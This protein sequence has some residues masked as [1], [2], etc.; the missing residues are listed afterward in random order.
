V[1]DP[2]EKRRGGGFRVVFALFPDS[3]VIM[4]KSSK[5]DRQILVPNYSNYHDGQ[6]SKL[7]PAWPLFA[8]HPPGWKRRSMSS[9]EHSDGE[10]QRTFFPSIHRPQ[11]S[12]K[13]HP[14]T[15]NKI[16]VAEAFLRKCLT[17]CSCAYYWTV[18]LLALARPRPGASVA[19]HHGARV[20]PFMR[21]HYWTI[22]TVGLLALAWPLACACVASQ[23]G[24]R[25]LPFVLFRQLACLRLRGSLLVRPWN[26]SMGCACCRSCCFI[27][28]IA[29]TNNHRAQRRQERPQGISSG[30]LLRQ[31]YS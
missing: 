24:A 7:L 22:W 14:W 19:S 27:T 1:R 29:T 18:G 31:I 2:S 23:H 5:K 15:N 20:L 4:K 10:S 30:I 6:F 12:A 21:I 11:P 13:K 28:D 25:V 17:P 26:V 9:D 16:T 3:R 8:R